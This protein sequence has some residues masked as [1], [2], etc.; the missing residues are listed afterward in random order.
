MVLVSEVVHPKGLS[1]A[2]CAHVAVR[3]DVHK[4]SFLNIASKVFNRRGHHPSKETV[5]VAYK[6]VNGPAKAG[7]KKYLYS[8]CG[9]KSWKVTKVVRSFLL[10]RLRALRTKT[11]CTATTLQRELLRDM[12]VKLDPSTIRKVLKKSGYKWL[13]R[14]V[15]QK[16]N[17]NHGL[18]RRQDQWAVDL[19]V[20]V[21][22]DFGASLEW[23]EDGLT[24]A[25]PGQKFLPFIRCVVW[26][27]F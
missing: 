20:G 21:V 1:V 18:V 13:K 4:E 26:P 17:P 15:E 24:F 10:K 2:T 19:R 22:G 7:G 5:R 11:V 6:A 16:E 25:P 9:R 27:C 8:R 14:I 23:R 12:G 3:R